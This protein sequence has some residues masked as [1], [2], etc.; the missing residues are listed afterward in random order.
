MKNRILIVDDEEIVVRSCLRILEGDD[1]EVEAVGDGWEAL[2][3][4]DEAATT[5]W[6]WTS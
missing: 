4:I 5:S 3:R 1:Y 6:C 2:R